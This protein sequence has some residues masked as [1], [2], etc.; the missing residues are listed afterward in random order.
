M[1]TISTLLDIGLMGYG[2]NIH[3]IRHW[4]DGMATISTLLDIRL[5][6]MAT[7]STLLD[8]GL[9]EGMATISTLFGIDL[10]VWLQYPLCL[11]LV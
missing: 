9:F 8:I 6:G 5:D 3:F 2:Y 10:M 4:F 7:I 11:A 1:A